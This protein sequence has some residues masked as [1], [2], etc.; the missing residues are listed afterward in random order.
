[1]LTYSHLPLVHQQAVDG[2]VLL[3]LS[4]DDLECLGVTTLGG[5]ATLMKKIETAKKQHYAGQVG[6]MP[7]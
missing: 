4:R 3:T 1:M 6:C 7:W 5:K 2:E